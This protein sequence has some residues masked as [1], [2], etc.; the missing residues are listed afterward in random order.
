MF[1]RSTYHR[2]T[3]ESSGNEKIRATGKVT[4]PHGEQSEWRRAEQTICVTGTM[5]WTND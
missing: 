2:P 4:K 1:Q 5:M 3:S